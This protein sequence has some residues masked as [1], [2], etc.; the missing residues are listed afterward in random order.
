M[1]LVKHLPVHRYSVDIFFSYSGPSG[2]LGSDAK[3]NTTYA[4]VRGRENGFTLTI[5]PTLLFSYYWRFSLFLKD[6]FSR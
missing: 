2:I 6:P 4:G 5:K 1:E 3:Q